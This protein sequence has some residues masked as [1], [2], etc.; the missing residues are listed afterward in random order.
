MPR[1]DQVLA[2][3][4]KVE[5]A[6]ARLKGELVIDAV[7][8]DYYARLP[9]PCMGGWARQSLN[10]TPSGKALPCH[11]AETI[12]R[13]VF[14]NVRDTALD[15]I[16]YD[17]PAFNAFRGTAWMPEPCRSCERRELD[18]GGCRCQAL[19]ITGQAENADPACHKSPH[20]GEMLRMAEE[21]SGQA[22]DFRY[23]G[24]TPARA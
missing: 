3:M 5:A 9:K 2:A 17:S 14:P 8:P 20:H 12:G 1:R 21:D 24:F 23:R 11:A 7:V 19:A 4:E 15:D 18:W 22:A 10:V 16:W 6:R 13:L